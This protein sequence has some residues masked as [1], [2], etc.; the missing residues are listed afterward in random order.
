MSCTPTIKAKMN[1]FLFVLSL[2]LQKLHDWYATSIFISLQKSL[3]NT[4]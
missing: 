4:V 3:E 1:L 2:S